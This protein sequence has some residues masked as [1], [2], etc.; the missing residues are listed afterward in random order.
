MVKLIGQVKIFNREE[1]E[2]LRQR[3]GPV[4]LKF[5]K[6]VQQALDLKESLGIK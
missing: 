1:A 2:E 6:L 4:L 3:I 5:G